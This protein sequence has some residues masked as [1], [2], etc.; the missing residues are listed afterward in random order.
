M[1]RFRLLVSSLLLLGSFCSA[2]DEPIPLWGTAHGKGKV[3]LLGSIH[4]LKEDLSPYREMI[5]NAFA[6]SECLAVEAYI[7][8]QNM[9]ENAGKM[10]QAGTLP[11]GE[12]LET[13]LP[14]QKYD[15]LAALMKGLGFDIRSYQHYR[16]WMLALTISSLSMVKQGY[17]PMFGV[18][19]FFIRQ[20]ESRNM[21]IEELEGVD[22]Q[23]DLFKSLNPEEE[24]AFLF[25]SILEQKKQED[26]VDQ[27]VTAWKSG[28]VEALAAI[29]LK[30][31]RENPELKNFY[32]KLLKNRN[33]KM[34]DKIEDFIR[35]ERNC[36]VIVGAAH[37]I[38]ENGIV[39]LLR[40]KGYEVTLY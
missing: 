32:N 8:S 38:G 26:T 22:A 11:E 29:L 24:T 7:G 35:S 10:M 28:D 37:L 16:P 33:E 36:F 13:I 40:K 9:M 6:E 39:E 25:S 2:S 27:V 21:A 17:N 34:V 4:L 12:R 30:G 31:E 5:V 15:E 1:I 23:I 19:L 3:Y 14:D 18:D 20:A